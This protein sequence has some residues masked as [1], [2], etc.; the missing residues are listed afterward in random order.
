MMQPTTC[1]PGQLRAEVGT[2]S[3]MTSPQ[4]ASPTG[5]EFIKDEGLPRMRRATARRGAQAEVEQQRLQQPPRT[6]APGNTGG[7][8]TLAKHRPRCV[9]G[10]AND[11]QLSYNK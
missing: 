5:E 11:C 10:I 7:M 3:S 9:A 4:R 6:S 2:A 1:D 8:P